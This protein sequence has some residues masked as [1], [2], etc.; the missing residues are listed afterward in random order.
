MID[1]GWY[2]PSEGDGR[3][4]GTRIPE[5]PPSIDYLVSVARAAERAG[6]NE[7]LS[8]TGTVNDSFAPDAPFMESWTT[9]T[10]LAVS[11]RRIRLLVAINPAGLRPE[12]AAHQ[13]ETL[14]QMAPGRVAVNLVAG[15]GHVVL[16]GA[17]DGRGPGV[18]ADQDL[19]QPAFDAQVADRHADDDRVLR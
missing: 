7:I 11:T 1:L 5:R 14:A 4:L 16:G 13:V 2:C 8:P 17:L 18:L 12:L 6:A 3:W 10:A 15:G 9:A 19:A